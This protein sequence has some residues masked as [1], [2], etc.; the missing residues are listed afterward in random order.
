[1]NY[2]AHLYLSYPNHGLMVGNFIADSVKGGHYKDFP[3]QIKQG[4]LMHRS[5]DDFTDHHP[6]VLDSKKYFSKEFDKYSGVLIDL[7]FDYF[8]AR[9]FTLYSDVPLSAFAKNTYTILTNY[10]DIFPEHSVYFFEYMIKENILER[11]AK[12]EEMKKVLH[13]M[14]HRINERFPLYNSLSTFR[15][16]QGLLH[17]NFVPFFE[18]L[19]RHIAH[20]RENQPSV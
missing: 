12:L 17:N 1:M 20:F 10:K 6:L 15:D 9:D 3:E 7:Y 16:K 14:T 8:L 5:I 19:K 13:G 2:L 18:E 11:Y 4:I